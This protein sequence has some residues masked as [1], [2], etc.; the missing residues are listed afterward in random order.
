MSEAEMCGVA[1]FLGTVPN[2]H[3]V[4]SV[5]YPHNLELYQLDPPLHG[6]QVVAAAQAITA[7]QAVLIGDPIP[8]PLDDPVSTVLFGTSGGEKLQ[9]EWKQ[10]LLVAGGRAPVRA[11]TE[12]GYR[13]W[14]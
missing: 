10:G 13:V 4:Y 9:I 6:Y 1:R 5:V 2:D 14:R 7:A 8:E 3:Y 11:L 12:A